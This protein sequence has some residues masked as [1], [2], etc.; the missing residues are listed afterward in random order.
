[1]LNEYFT[2]LFELKANQKDK[3]I[4]DINIRLT[5]RLVIVSKD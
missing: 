4:V 3:S 5:S 2:L 1:M